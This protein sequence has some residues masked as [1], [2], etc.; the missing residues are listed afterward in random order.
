[1]TDRSSEDALTHAC[2]HCQLEF[3]A[4]TEFFYK[5]TKGSLSWGCKP[6]VV[7][8]NAAAKRRR[9]GSP[10]FRWITCEHCGADFMSAKPDGLVRHCT[11]VCHIAA[12][13]AEDKAQRL[14]AKGALSRTCMWC[15]DR[16]AAAKRMDAKYC[17]VACNERAHSRTRRF[18][19]RL[20]EAS[21]RPA[22]EPLL[23]LADIAAR[24]EWRCGLCGL[25]VDRD[26]RHP[27]PQAPSL[28]HIEPLARGGTNDPDNI[29]LAHLRCNVRKRDRIDF[30]L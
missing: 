17:S 2:R 21:T 30:V 7:A 12:R 26:R 25:P 14:A 20:G 9:K 18:R 3:P 22:S 19:R 13:Q 28:D 16:I 23:N 5:D 8:R 10:G 15:G 24:S 29:Q 11:L 4:T 27:D 6:C 1:M